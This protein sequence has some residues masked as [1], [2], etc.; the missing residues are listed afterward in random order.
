MNEEPKKRPRRKLLQVAALTAGATVS[1]G[2]A[3]SG[4]SEAIGVD[5]VAPPQDATDSFSI[6][7]D[8]GRSPQDAGP[9][10]SDATDAQDSF[11]TGLDVGAPPQDVSVVEAGT[12]V[13]DAGS[14]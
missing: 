5:V 4:C 10:S 14:E 7:I 9:D 3:M 11:V 1:A 6:G 2:L 13:A 8:A 12:T